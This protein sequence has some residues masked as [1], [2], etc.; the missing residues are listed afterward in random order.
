M[1]Y[2]IIVS[3][4]WAFSFGLIK[5]NL[6]GIDASFVAFARLFIS[7]LFFTFFLRIKHFKARQIGQLM[8]IGALQFG[9]MYIF[10]IY[11]YDY[12]KAW[13]IALFTIFTPLY[14]TFINDLLDKK[15]NWKF[16][17]A[18][19]LSIAGAGIIVFNTEQGLQLQTGFILIQFSNICFAAGQIF[20]KRIRKHFIN[21]KDKSLF[22]WIYCGALI[23]SG[24]NSFF[25]TDYSAIQLDSVQIYTLLYLGILASGVCFFLWNIGATKVNAGT[26]A[27]FNNIKVPLGVAVSI[28]IFNEDGDLFRMIISGI[29][30]ALALYI[31]EYFNIKNLN[32]IKNT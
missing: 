24:L 25:L 27:V 18:S 9:L 29:M 31:S 1:I 20:Y 22:A 12:L 19:L 6:S 15:F 10:Y 14:V 17:I 2:L 21:I 4:I 30:L 28:L 8:A 16:L 11:A 23:I 5:G 13:Q 26:L 3:L 7:F 32:W